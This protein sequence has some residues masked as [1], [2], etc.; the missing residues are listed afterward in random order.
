M[1]DVI[2]LVRAITVKARSSAKRKERLKNLQTCAGRTSTLT[3]LL[4]MKVRWS[5]TYNM[6]SRALQLREYI[7]DF[8]YETGREEPDL[9]KRAKIDKLILSDDEWTLVKLVVELLGFADCAQQAFSYDDSPT[10]HSGIPALEALHKAWSSRAKRP[11]YQD[12]TEALAAAAEKIEEYYE[13]TSTSHAYTLV[14]LLDPEK[15]MDYFKKHWSE[16]LQKEVIE[17][18]EEIERYYEIHGKG[19]SPPVPTQTSSQKKLSKLLDELSDSDDEGPTVPPAGASS[20]DSQKPWLREFRLYLDATHRVSDGTSLIKW[21]GMH[22]SDFPVWAS[23]ARDY[24]AIMASSVSSERA[25]SSAGITISKRRNRLKGDIVEALQFLKCL[26]RK[27]LIFRE[28]APSSILEAEYADVPEDDGDPDWVDE[29]P[30]AWDGLII[31]LDVDSDDEI[32][33]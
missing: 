8:I 3:L 7:K 31:D 23:L 32:E 12:F 10:L 4:D 30:K 15:K 26:F 27:D 28:H 29:N 11:K 6:L 25:F 20:A 13:K 2:G 16:E 9:E 33:I 24:L 5:S 19:T 17:S 18:A 22:A 21:W 14:M 1:R